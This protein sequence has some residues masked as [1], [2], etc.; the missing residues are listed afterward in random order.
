LLAVALLSA[1]AVAAAGSAAAYR[2][3]KVQTVVVAEARPGFINVQPGGIGPVTAPT[4]VP[5]ILD[6]LIFRGR[7]VVSSVSVLPGA[8][9]TKG[10]ALFSLDPTALS[11]V[12]S[13]IS[14]RLQSAQAS[15]A[16]EQATSAGAGQAQIVALQARISSLETVRTNDQAR[17]V[18]A[19]G[20]GNQGAIIAAQN[21]FSRDDAS[22]TAAQ[23][24]LNQLWVQ[25]AATGAASGV[26]IEQ[27]QAQV[28]IYQQLA[29]VASGATATI[30]A[31]IDGLV[32][33]IAVHPGQ[34]AGAG[35]ALVE[36]EDLAT[37]R[38]TASFPFADQPQVQVGAPALV[39]F[40]GSPGV[41][42][43]GAVVSVIP[44]AVSG[45]L[46]FKALIDAPNTPD[47][48]VEPG[49]VGFVRVQAQRQAALTVPRL[50][51]LN[52]DLAP[53]V[54]VIRNGRAERRSVQVGAI[55]Q[56]TVEVLAGLKPG[57]LCVVAGSQTLET[58][59]RVT[60]QRLSLP[61]QVE[62]TSSART[63]AP[64]PSP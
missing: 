15:L 14:L 53:T 31:P 21:A 4:R 2:A 22:L 57:E 52:L 44:E 48:R 63:S 16:R 8:R 13:Q 19:Q 41:V 25:S 61:R 55:D 20:S 58:G 18:T 17:L 43:N 5:V 32:S 42:L 26:R 12:T 38:V 34:P 1:A 64:S 23:A 49:L 50:A 7:I 46:A 45:G 60:V 59:A 39:S 24:Q 6:P 3:H 54:Y 11:A 37:I 33:A 36:I 47:Q 28:A 35:I 56:D 10:Q 40:N 9:V 29:N 30:A 62:I 27:L 51:A